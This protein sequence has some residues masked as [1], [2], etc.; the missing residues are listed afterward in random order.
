MEG[1]Q[2]RKQILERHRKKQPDRV[3]KSKM[4]SDDYAGDLHRDV[5]LTAGLV[6]QRLGTYLPGSFG[7][8]LAGTRTDMFRER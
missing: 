3:E 1:K 2:K 8:V 6:M 7:L 4:Q 5:L